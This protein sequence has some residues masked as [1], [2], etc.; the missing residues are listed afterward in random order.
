MSERSKGL[1]ALERWRGFGEDRAAS[2][3]LL[4]VQAAAAAGAAAQRDLAHARG[5]AAQRLALQQQPL[6]DLGRVNV[7]AAMEQAAWRAV[8]HSQQ[9]QQQAD[10]AAETAREHHET[11][12]R[13]TQAVA[14]RLQRVRAQERDAAEKHLFDSLAE[15]RRPVS[16]GPHD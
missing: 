10:A 9:R 11:A 15:L 1:R 6:L 13:M 14:Q 4:A 5:E 3:R 8:E 16:G 2:A 12:H 7:C